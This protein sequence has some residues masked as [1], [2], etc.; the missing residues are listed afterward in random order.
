MDAHKESAMK[1]LSKVS[2]P[3]TMS[4]LAYTI[5]KEEQALGMSV[6]FLSDRNNSETAVNVTVNKVTYSSKTIWL[7]VKGH[8]IRGTFMLDALK[9]CWIPLS[10]SPAKKLEEVPPNVQVQAKK[11]ARR[12]ILQDIDPREFKRLNTIQQF[13]H[14]CFRSPPRISDRI[15]VTPLSKLPINLDE[16]GN[17]ISSISN[18]SNS[19][20]RLYFAGRKQILETNL[21]AVMEIMFYINIKEGSENGI[22]GDFSTETDEQAAAVQSDLLQIC[23]GIFPGLRKFCWTTEKELANLPLREICV[24]I[25]KDAKL[26]AAGNLATSCCR[27]R[28]RSPT[29]TAFIAL[30]I[31]LGIV[32]GEHS[33]DPDT[34]IRI[35]NARRSECGFYTTLIERVR[36][37]MHYALMRRGETQVGLTHFLA[38]Q[39]S[40]Y[41]SINVLFISTHIVK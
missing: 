37:D 14:L 41:N 33:S 21:C 20:G 31:E 35:L 28:S 12:C 36:A 38:D 15:D 34:L 1:E 2:V 7:S 5:L 18:G 24:A 23:R 27:G 11:T 32:L 19:H 17:E 16:T 10:S 39:D 22:S 9:D 8:P 25:G 13:V 30:V 4:G 6:S 40:R 29:V 26:L 3:G